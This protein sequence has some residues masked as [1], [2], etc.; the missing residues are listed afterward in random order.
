M[1]SDSCDEMKREWDKLP[2]TSESFLK[3]KFLRVYFPVYK[4]IGT[5]IVVSHNVFGEIRWSLILN[6]FQSILVP[7]GETKE[8][9]LSRKV[10]NFGGPFYQSSSTQSTCY[11]RVNEVACPS[12]G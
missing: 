2:R 5:F 8:K 10:Y 4:E 3:S 6:I 1:E 12:S 7:V 9:K 11:K